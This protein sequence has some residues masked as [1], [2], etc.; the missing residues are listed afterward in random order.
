MTGRRPFSD[1]TQGWSP[2]RIARNKTN[3]AAFATEFGIPDRPSALT[4][5]VEESFPA[6]TDAKSDVAPGIR[7]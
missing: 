2:K 1:L 7:R 6:P 5:A 3:K 4:D